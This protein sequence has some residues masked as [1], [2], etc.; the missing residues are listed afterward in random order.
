M[1]IQRAEISLGWNS[2][3]HWLDLNKFPGYDCKYECSLLNPIMGSHS[4]DCLPTLWPRAISRSNRGHTIWRSWRRTLH[5]QAWIVVSFVNVIFLCVGLN[6]E[7]SAA[8]S[9]TFDE[10]VCFQLPRTFWNLLGPWP[11]QTPGKHHSRDQ[12]FYTHMLN[13]LRVVTFLVVNNC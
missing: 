1:R 4:G 2:G 12:N 8:F 9:T 3:A 11:P 10:C 5:D 7:P 13:M 6:S